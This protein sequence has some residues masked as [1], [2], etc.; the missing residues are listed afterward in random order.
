MFQEM[1]SKC[2]EERNLKIEAEGD[3]AALAQKIEKL[4]SLMQ[5]EEK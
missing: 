1:T 4:K 5:D 2:N 3:T